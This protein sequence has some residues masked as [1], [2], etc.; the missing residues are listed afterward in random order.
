M[1]SVPCSA[2]PRRT[3]GAR[4]EMLARMRQ[5]F[6]HWLPVL[7]WLPIACLSMPAA[8]T[9]SSTLVADTYNVID[10]G[11]TYAV[12]DVYVTG[13]SLGDVMGGSVTGLAGGANTHAVIFATSGATGTGLTRDSAGR[14]TAGTITGDLF[15]Q[16]GGSNWLPTNTD[17]KGWDSFIAAGNRGQGTMAKVTNRA[18]VLK[19]QGLAANMSA[20]SGFSQMTVANSSYIDNGTSSG[21]FSAFGGNPYTTG[22]VAENPFARVSLYNA[23]WNAT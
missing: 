1:T 7:A 8:A 11:R 16:S 12:L 19:D 21:W 13:T 5:F 15:V 4:I 20:A 14:L 2:A 17:G 22:G 18:S 9:V 3:Q 23:D 6:V 10:G